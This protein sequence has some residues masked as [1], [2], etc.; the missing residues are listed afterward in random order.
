MN[1]WTGKKIRLRGLEPEDYEFF[2]N[3]NQDTETARNIAW[4]WFPTSKASVQEWAQSESLKKGEND[5]FFF[6]IETL[7]GEP[8]G[9]INANSVS[10]LDGSFR[11]G[12]GIVDKARRKGYAKEAIQIFLNYYFNELRYNKVNAGVYE[13]N[14]NSITLHQKMGFVQ[15]GRLRQTKYSQGK[16]WDVFIFGM[17]REE[18]N[19]K[20]AQGVF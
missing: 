12:V 9:S 10:K 11:Y 16:Y 14:E 8:V 5:E 3:W 17:T 13:F 2:Y 20:V 18:Y 1:Y 4:L 7:D 15:E 19:Q 6:V